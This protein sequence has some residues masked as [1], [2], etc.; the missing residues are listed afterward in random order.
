MKAFNLWLD[1]AAEPQR[2][3]AIG[4]CVDADFLPNDGFLETEAQ[5]KK[6]LADTGFRRTDDQRRLY[7]HHQSG[8]KASFW[9]APSHGND[10]YIESLALESL[11]ADEVAYLTKYV[12][13]FVNGM[14]VPR[15]QEK[16]INRANL[17]V[18]L[19]IQHKPDKS[20]PTL[21]DDGKVDFSKP[22]IAELKN[23]LVNL[24]GK[25]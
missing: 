1:E 20:L 25:K 22:S 9:I 14:D 23:W 8:C 2:Y 21:M 19:G 3:E 6:T 5:L 11:T 15:F 13:P 12:L 4:I 24:F 17:Y 16:N 18:Y 7:Q 10:G